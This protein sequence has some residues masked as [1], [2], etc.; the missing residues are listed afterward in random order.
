MRFQPFTS[1]DVIHRMNPDAEDRFTIPPPLDTG[2]VLDAAHLVE[3]GIFG[4][5][6]MDVR[7]HSFVMLRSQILNRFH[8]EGG[9]VLAVTSTQ[10]GN[11]KTFVTA[12]LAAA[13]SH[14][15][16][17]VLIDLDLRRPTLASRFGLTTYRGIDDY[18]AGDAPFTQTGIRVAGV[19]LVVHGGRQPRRDSA[20]LLAD[21]RVGQMMTALRDRAEG[22]VC[23]VDTPPIMALD[24]IMLIA[25]HVDGVLLVIEEGDTRSADVI[26]SLRLL[27]PTP[28]IGTVLNKSLTRE[29]LPSSYAAYYDW[30]A[31]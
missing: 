4:F 23:I 28:I 1:G 10:P 20:T 21:D 24:D 30:T 15:H 11:G 19:D 31:D 5:D 2:V 7:A 3:N 8:R 13:M 9:R 25:R 27:A 29:R 22:P 14:I 18:L 12:N 26:E 6:P 17:T 16:P